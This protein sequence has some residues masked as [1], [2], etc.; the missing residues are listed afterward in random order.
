MHKIFKLALIIDIAIVI[1]VV[2][3]IMYFIDY[4]TERLMETMD[5]YNSCVQEKY[6]MSVYQ[7]KNEQGEM[8]VCG[9]F[10]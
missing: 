1:I 5:K 3:G 7:F 10:K 4:R 6:G 9:K 2:S 8:P